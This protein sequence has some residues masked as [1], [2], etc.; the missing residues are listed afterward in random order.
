MT[1]VMYPHPRPGPPS[2]GSLKIKPGT[3]PSLMIIRALLLAPTFLERLL[4]MLINAVCTLE[5]L[6]FVSL[7]MKR[8]KIAKKKDP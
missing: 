8:N 1:P 7:L 6:D 4:S 2:S 5:Q 3:I